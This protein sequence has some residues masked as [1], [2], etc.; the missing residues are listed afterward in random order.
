MYQRNHVSPT[1][2]ASANIC[3]FFFSSIWIRML[4]RKG[5]GSILRREETTSH[6]FSHNDD[7]IDIV[8]RISAKRTY[9]TYERFFAATSHPEKTTLLVFCSLF[10]RCSFPTRIV[11]K[12]A[13]FSTISYEAWCRSHARSRRKEFT[14]ICGSAA[15]WLRK[16]TR[17]RLYSCLLR[18]T[19]TQSKAVHDVLGSVSVR[20][21]WCWFNA[22]PHE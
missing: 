20:C 2:F 9:W 22:A 16:G 14:T 7:R 19:T 18:G 5:F 4:R 13:S 17:S 21:I 12:A 6:N 11:A 1:R 3:Q 15:C 8:L 10:K